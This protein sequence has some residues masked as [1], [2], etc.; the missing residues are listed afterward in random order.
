MSELSWTA[1]RRDLNGN[2]RSKLPGKKFLFYFEFPEAGQ[3]SGCRLCDWNK[4][5]KDIEIIENMHLCHLLFNLLYKFKSFY[6]TNKMTHKPHWVCVCVQVFLE[7]WN[8]HKPALPKITEV[9][10]QGKKEKRKSLVTISQIQNLALTLES[11]S[12]SPAFPI[13]L[14]RS[15]Q[16]R[17]PYR[18]YVIFCDLKRWC[19]GA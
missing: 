3:R 6:A 14:P 1:E 9:R 2:Y 16:E 19:S 18:W 15:N 4:N 5:R 11:V 7:F 17:W 12:Y 10:K 13:D 8:D